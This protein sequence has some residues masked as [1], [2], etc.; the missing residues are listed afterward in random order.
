MNSSGS[1]QKFLKP[2][3]TSLLCG[4]LAL[5][6]LASAAQAQSSP[7]VAISTPDT[8]A[9]PLVT[10]YFWPIDSDGAFISGLTADD[11]HVTENDR[12]VKVAS[13][14][15]LEPGTHV[16]LAVNE[17]KTLANSYAGE[18]RMNRMKDVI[19]TWIKSE[20]ITTLDDFSL[21]NNS[22]T[23][24]NQLAHPAD[25]TQAIADYQPDLRAAVPSLNSLSQAITLVKDLPSTDHKAKVIL[26]ITPLPDTDSFTALQQQGTLAEQLNTRLFIWLIGPS[27]YH[28]EPGAL[29]L[30]K[31]AEATGGS[32]F[33]YSGAEELPDLNT[34]L[35]PLSHEYK[36]T[37]QTQIQKSGSF[38]LKVSVN[39]N[40]I[41]LTSSSVP[42]DLKVAAPNPILLS[43][44][45]NI[46]LSWSQAD[47]KSPWVISPNLYTLKYML[48][49][50]DNHERAITAARLF[51]DGKLES[52]VT[53]A[54]FDELKWDLSQ[55]SET[56]THYVQV[57]VEDGAGFSA[58]TIKTPITVTVNPKPLT[59]FQKFL[60][61]INYT[62][63]GIVGFLVL[64]AIILLLLFQKNKLKKPWFL[65]SR[66]SAENDPVKQP[67]EIEQA[68]DFSDRSI[69]APSDWPK[70]P[71]GGKALARLISTQSSDEIQN[72]ALPL[73]DTFFG[74]DTVR[75]DIVLNGPTISAV[76]AK[77]YTDSAKHFFIADCGS[78]A[79]T[80]LNYAPVSQQGTR[81]Q[82][83][84]LINIGAATFR[85]EEIS[86]EGRPIQVISIKV[87]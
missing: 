46:T 60:D 37:Y 51:V 86:P 40:N 47:K 24:Q 8:S 87:E 66:T 41:D 38:S 44:P 20:S 6:V 50:P 82:H 77:I 45:Q 34:Y 33:I 85:F 10:F 16:I 70:L 83:G 29:A 23:L 68:D 21:I 73:Q 55:Y 13:L 5:C 9:Y 67:V 43:P 30:E 78:N 64:L 48:E 56:G 76:H 75:S 27:S 49:F 14:D 4:L 2:A 71:G 59:P 54:P 79:G 84:D 62:T 72:I 25:W 69:Q 26:Y 17:G 3:V 57:F 28:T 32:F 61:S 22:E 12:E 81:L 19:T 18:T 52:E 11:I 63:L 1:N 65:R 53:E 36:V 58:S 74:S 31:M 42:F 15:L 7:T 80:W 39:H 35:N